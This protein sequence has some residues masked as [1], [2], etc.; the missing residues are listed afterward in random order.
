M[1]GADVQSPACPPGRWLRARSK[2]QMH[3]VEIAGV[4]RPLSRLALG[5]MMF[6]KVAEPEAFDVLDAFYE[7]GG[8]TFDTAHI[9]GMGACERALG[10]WIAQHGVRDKVVII[11][12]G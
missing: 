7:R 12:K 3:Y 11:D 2:P 10:R 8:N 5:T 4:S 9:Y 1:F 6:S